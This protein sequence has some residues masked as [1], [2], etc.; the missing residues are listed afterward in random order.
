MGNGH[1][2]YPILPPNPLFPTSR[3]DGRW[4]VRGARCELGDCV[5]EEVRSDFLDWTKR[6]G[7]QLW[8]TIRQ[9]PGAFQ[10]APVKA[11]T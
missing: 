11:I 9:N 7:G 6:R 4:E 1:L 3:P 5:I 2:M 10:M 8:A